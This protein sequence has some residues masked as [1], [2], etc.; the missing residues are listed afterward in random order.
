[1]CVQGLWRYP[2]KSLAGETLH[3]AR[4]TADGIAGDQMVHVRGRRG[5]LTGRT[6]HRLLT[7]PAAPQ[8]DRRLLAADRRIRDP[9]LIAAVDPP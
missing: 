2:V 7:I 8:V 6:R 5:P 3:E 9:P 1:M 4:L